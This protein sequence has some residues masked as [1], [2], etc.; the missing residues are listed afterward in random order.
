M[1]KDNK[2]AQVVVVVIYTKYICVLLVM[3]QLISTEYEFV[4]L[5]T[6]SN[7]VC[8]APS[9]LA[10]GVTVVQP[11]T[12]TVSSVIDY[13]CQQPGFAFSPPSSVCR[14]DGRWSPDPSQMVCMVTLTTTLPTSASPAGRAGEYRYHGT[15]QNVCQVL[16][17]L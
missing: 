10:N 12:T 2:L 17:L 11:H 5:F 4:P 9:T 14:E 15:I 1:V 6:A 7:V 13:Q 3:F 16:G 8:G